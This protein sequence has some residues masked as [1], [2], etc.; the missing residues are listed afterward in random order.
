MRLQ[1]QHHFFQ[2][3]KV[4][5]GQVE[6]LEQL[7]FLPV[8]LHPLGRLLLRFHRV[9]DRGSH[10]QVGE[11]ADDEGEGPHVLP[12]HGGVVS[13]RGTGGVS[14]R[15]LRTGNSAGSW[16]C[17]SDG[18]EELSDYF[19]SGGAVHSAPRLPHPPPTPLHASI[20]PLSHT[21][22]LS[23]RLHVSHFNSPYDILDS[24][25]NLEHCAPMLQ[26]N[27]QPLLKHSEK[28]YAHI[29]EK[30]MEDK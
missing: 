7:P 10:D 30:E 13:V 11:G 1:L 2:L 12:L 16:L 24:L 29:R 22:T 3:V 28:I 27:R 8:Q 23:L 4:L 21:H 26:K 14:E 5:R 9:E 19:M 6:C 20:P 25:R 18:A 17:C 15:V